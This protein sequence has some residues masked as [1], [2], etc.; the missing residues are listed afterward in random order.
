MW[1]SPHLLKFSI[2]FVAAGG[3]LSQVFDPRRL[4]SGTLA[5]TP[6]IG[7]HATCPRADKIIWESKSQNGQ[8]N[9]QEKLACPCWHLIAIISSTWFFKQG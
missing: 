7:L 3:Q 6:S 4:I 8:K 5:V 1:V 2:Y 9:E